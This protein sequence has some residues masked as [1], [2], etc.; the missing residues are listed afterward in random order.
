MSYLPQLR[1]SLIEAAQRQHETGERP[2]DQPAP[3]PARGRARL[4]RGRA[5]LLAAVVILVAAAVA[6]AA[7]G[8]LQ[9][10]RPIGPRLP[11]SPRTGNG[12]AV[13]GS[14]TLLPLRVADPADGL[15]WGLRVMHTTR[16][17]ACIQVGRVDFAT[18][19]VLGRD[20]AFA[21]DG[22]FHPLATSYLAGVPFGCAVTDVR[23]NGFQ[24]VSIEAIPASGLIGGPTS[25]G[26]C[27][28][29]GETYSGPR[30]ATCPA[31]DL[32]D[33]Y[34][35]LLGPDATD[36]TYRTASGALVTT[37]TA[38]SDG[39]YLVVLPHTTPAC[40]TTSVPPGVRHRHPPRRICS[41]GQRVTGGPD[42]EAGAIVSVTYRDGHTCHTPPPGLVA[43]GPGC[44]PVGF[45]AP[46]EPRVNAAQLATPI[47]IREIPAKAYCTPPHSATT[48]PCPSRTPPGFKRLTGGPPSLLV[49]IS[50][51]SRIAIP[52]SRS[53]YN[54][55]VTGARSPTCTVNAGQFGSTNSDI[56]AGQRVAMR[57]LVPYSCPGLAHGTVS[58]IPT[59]GPASS[60]A[61]E[62]LPGQMQSVPVGRFSFK[63]P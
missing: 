57:F 49:E 33:V 54:F 35:G 55:T 36:V 28:E 9:R 25:A 48:E 15:P 42:V 30:Q 7:T 52:D 24:N 3:A 20:G 17:L 32:R 50:L 2:G 21:D 46:A 13:P 58:Y 14:A 10:G 63:I 31:A 29:A 62:G 47:T 16:G 22:R 53:Y 40:A 27:H 12:T 6:V 1:A 39:A 34:Y 11:P 56:R 37:P 41:A 45:V 38:G 60:M 26:G 4:Q 51:T 59:T 8:V 19:G 23:G 18:V 61:V 43:Q 5:V 44:P